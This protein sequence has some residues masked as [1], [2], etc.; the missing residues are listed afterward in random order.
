MNAR[1]LTIKF[2]SYAHYIASREWASE[3]SRPPFL[4]CVAPDIAQERR[5]LCVAQ[6]ML[7]PALRLV[8]WTTTEE[9]LVRFGSL[10]PV[11]L[12]NFPNRS[13]TLQNSKAHRHSWAEMLS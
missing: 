3:E 5:I 13:H 7:A 11:W 1:D 10:A 4:V 2:T 9:L 6:A 8:V 12:Q